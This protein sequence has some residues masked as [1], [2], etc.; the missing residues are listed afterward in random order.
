ME[1]DQWS[2]QAKMNPARR[3]APDKSG[4]R[5]LGGTGLSFSLRFSF[6]DGLKL[7]EDW[8]KQLAAFQL[9][10]ANDSDCP[11]PRI[12][13]T[14]GGRRQ[15]IQTFRQIQNLKAPAVCFRKVSGERAGRLGR[16]T[17]PTQPD[18]KGFRR[19]ALG[20]KDLSGDAGVSA[21]QDH[22]QVVRR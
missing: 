5:I 20:G 21:L 14:L 6:L 7:N 22:H 15:V 4:T 19:P 9:E 13:R 11:P 12:K 2:K 16:L 17:L 18:S 8:T 10:I 1:G 3:R